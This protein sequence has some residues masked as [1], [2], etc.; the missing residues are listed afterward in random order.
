MMVTDDHIYTPFTRIL[1]L[2]IGLD[3]AVQSYY[4][5]ESIFRSPVYSLI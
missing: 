4:K 2:L 1:D 3:A 5:T